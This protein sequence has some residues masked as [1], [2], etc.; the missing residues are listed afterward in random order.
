MSQKSRFRP[1]SIP[2]AFVRAARRVWD[3]PAAR[4]LLSG[5]ALAGAAWLIWRDL[6]GVDPATILVAMG[7]VSPWALGLAMVMT[8]ASHMC[9]AIVE[10]F[11]LRGVGRP[12][13]LAPT[14]RRGF[15]A[16]AFSSLVGFG[17]ASGTALRMRIYAGT[18][19]TPK[20]VAELVLLTTSATYLAGVVTLGLSLLAAPSGLAL[21][22]GAPRGAVWALAFPLL[23]P[24]GL[25]F[26]VLRRRGDE[27]SAPLTRRDRVL[28]LSAGLGDWLTSGA[29]LFVLG[30]ATLDALP[31]FLAVFCLGSLLGGLAGV[32]GGIGILEAT[33]LRLG[34]S[35][36]LHV[37]AAALI[38]YRVIYLLGPAVVAALVLAVGQARRLRRR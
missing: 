17:P 30:G 1:A 11:A 10:W 29:A 21:A 3:H 16:N 14:L 13:P 25:W 4:L 27:G 35:A 24:A 31:R 15:I 9:L 2:A 26:T 6:K 20:V 37:A 8:A 18:G 12:A 38:L 5:A 23:A 32:P 28:A 22:I 19:L 33:V 36:Q 34:G 7:A